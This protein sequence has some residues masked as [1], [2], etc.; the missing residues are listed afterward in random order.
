MQSDTKAYYV[1]RRHL[2]VI[3]YDFGL[4]VHHAAHHEPEYA[5]ADPGESEDH[6]EADEERVAVV[7]SFSGL[8]DLLEPASTA[9]VKQRKGAFG[10][11]RLTSP[12]QRISTLQRPTPPMSTLLQNFGTIAMTEVTAPRALT[13]SSGIAI[14]LALFIYILIVKNLSDRT[15]I[16]L[17]N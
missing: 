9:R 3:A 14:F 2:N 17:E 12:L 11:S 13:V 1:V 5:R 10:W 16:N 6:T 7:L 15:V 4:P 8:L